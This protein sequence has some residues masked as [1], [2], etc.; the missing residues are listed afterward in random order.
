MSRRSANSSSISEF[1]RSQSSAVARFIVDQHAARIRK[2]G[3][4]NVA[5]FLISR[6]DCQSSELKECYQAIKETILN[7]FAYKSG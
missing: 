6:Q 5:D 4:H 7:E 2:A 1:E 3:N